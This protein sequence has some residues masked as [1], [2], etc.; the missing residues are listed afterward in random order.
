PAGTAADRVP[1]VT[2]AQARRVFGAY[3][4]KTDSALAA[5]DEKAA[6]AMT[7]SVAHTELSNAFRTAGARHATVRPY[8][9]G[10]PEFYLPEQHGYPRWFIASVHAAA[11]A[12]ASSAASGK[13]PAPVSPS[14]A[15]LAGVRRPPSGQVLM[16]FTE[17]APKQPWQLASSVQLEPGQRL[18]KLATTAGGYVQTAPLGNSTAYLARP[19]V[20]GP[21]QAAVVDDG[22]AAPAATAVASG[23]LTTGI[24]ASQATIKPPR[25][26][27][28]QWLLEGANEERFALRTASG[29]AVVFYAMYLNDTTEVP[30]ELNQASVVPPGKPIA[31]PPDFAPLLSGAEPRKQ[32]TTQYLLAFAA[33]DPSASLPNARIRLIAM[34]GAPN[35]ASSS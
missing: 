21:L 23:P 19:D 33:I 35:W 4:S 28:R 27:V 31:I 9:Y 7:Q 15:I 18:P 13:N 3:V 16:L 17:Q 22:P 25:G 30:A 29:G 14:P 12:S 11:P 6:L 32:L 1:A 20:V 8:H 5:G 10:K 24:H 34:G 2:T 26:D